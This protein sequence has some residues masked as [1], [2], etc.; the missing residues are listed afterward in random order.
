MVKR[1]Y[2]K[3][4]PDTY[5]VI[6]TPPAFL[7]CKSASVILN[8]EQFERYNTW[9]SGKTLIQDALKDL[10]AEEREILITGIDQANWDRMFGSKDE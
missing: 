5:E 9:L 1:E 6:V 10:S 3:I 4:S 2:R 7:G 8:Q